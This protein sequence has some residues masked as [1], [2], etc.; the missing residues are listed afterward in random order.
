MYNLLPVVP[1]GK[2]KTKR[3]PKEPPGGTSKDC[4]ESTKLPLAGDSGISDVIHY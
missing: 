1:K 4:S 2:R 3:T